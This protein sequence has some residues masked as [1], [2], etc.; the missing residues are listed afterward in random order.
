MAEA[1][2][3]QQSLLPKR[4]TIVNRVAVCCRYIPFRHLVATVRLR[5]QRRADRITHCGCVRARRLCGDAHGHREERVP[6]VARRRIRAHRRRAACLDGARGVQRGSIRHDGRRS[7]ISGRTSVAVCERRPSARRSLGRHA[8]SAMAPQHRAA[9][10][11][12]ADGLDLGS[13]G[14][15]NTRGRSPS[16]VHGRHLRAL[17]DDNGRAEKRFTSIIDRASEGGAPLL[18]RF[19]AD[20][21]RNWRAAR[22]PTIFTLLTARVLGPT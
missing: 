9:G 12:G 3:F 19:L 17:A 7:D 20:V 1:R 5:G 10:I 2:A 16:A 21:H 8:R 18:D 11:A 6:C 15:A 14:R 22:S 4:E 13:A